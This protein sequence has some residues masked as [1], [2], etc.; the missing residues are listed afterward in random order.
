[1]TRIQRSL[2]LCAALASAAA[3]LSASGG[4]AYS[5]SVLVDGMAVRTVSTTSLGLSLPATRPE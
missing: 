5:L 4:P 1:M 3:S 2:L